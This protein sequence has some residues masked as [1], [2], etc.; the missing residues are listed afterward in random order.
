[1]LWRTYGA[2]E[3][4]GHLTGHKGAVLDL[5]WS[6]DASSLFSA[7]ADTTIASWDLETGTRIR[8]HI[9]HDE[10][11]N[12]LDISRRGFALLFSGSDDGS[13]GVWDPR[14]KAAADY[15]E[16]EYPITAVAMSEQGHELYTGGIDNAVHAWDLRKKAVAYS[17][18]GHA[19]TIT[20]LAVSPDGQM[21]LSLAHD[22]TA[23]SWDVKPFAPADRHVVTF[24]GAPPGLERNLIRASWDPS[25]ARV[26]AGS[27]DRSVVVWEARTGKLLYKLPGHKGT[28]NDVRFSPTG[29]P[30]SM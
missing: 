5:Q 19:D 2:C 6:R 21:L 23:R 27:G 30:I 18:P 9:G 20:S 22:G 17:M 24:D 7:S 25:G 29:Q 13:V 4:F 3:N 15:L 8:R 11:V 26:A 1:M 10:V 28:V 16:T 14:Q 12:C